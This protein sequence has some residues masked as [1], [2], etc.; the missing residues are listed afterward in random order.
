MPPVA[1]SIVKVPSPPTLASIASGAAVG[2]VTVT[3]VVFVSPHCASEN[4]TAAG[5]TTNDAPPSAPSAPPSFS[6]AGSMT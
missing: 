5:A 2:L 4:V 3:A 1:P 6:T